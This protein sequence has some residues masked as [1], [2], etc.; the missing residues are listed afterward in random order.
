MAISSMPSMPS[1]PLRRARPSFSRSSTGLIPC[2]ASSSPAGRDRAVGAFR[3]AL[4]HQGQ[5]AVRQR[6]EVAGAAERTVLVDHRGDAGVEHV[7]HGLRDLG[8]YAG[9]ARADGLQP[10]EH[11]RPHDLALDARAHAG[12]VRADDVAL[13]LGAQLRADVPGRERAEAGGDAV[14]RLRLRGQGLHDLP[15]AAARAARAS[16][17]ELDAGAVAGHGEHVLGRG[18]G[19]PDHHSVHIHIQERTD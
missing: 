6:R 14:D 18:A 5:G 2:S 13:Q 11:Q 3:V 17:G 9:V 1:V 16:A 12:G 10:Q 4:A 19:C 8:P 7:R 15:R